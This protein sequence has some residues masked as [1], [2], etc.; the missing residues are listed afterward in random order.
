MFLSILAT[1]S[2]VASAIT[3]IFTF[4]IFRRNSKPKISLEVMGNGYHELY[5]EYLIRNH[6]Y[7]DEQQSTAMIQVEIQN[8]SSIAGTITNIFLVPKSKNSQ[9]SQ[10]TT[11]YKNYTIKK[12]NFIY[13]SSNLSEWYNK[14]YQNLKQPITVPPYGYLIGFLL[15]PNFNVITE[16]NEIEV[17]LEYTIVGV[18]DCKKNV[19][20]VRSAFPLCEFEPKYKAIDNSKE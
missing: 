14:E 19:R 1:A 3:A 2:A 10:T 11:S 18:K 4:V 7:I 20:L 16:A 6:F 5:N 17:S 15:A 8:T 9:P 13:I 12:Y